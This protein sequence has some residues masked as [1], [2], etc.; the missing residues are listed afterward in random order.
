MLRQLGLSLL[1]ALCTALGQFAFAQ[2]RPMNT[3][4]IQGIMISAE[5]FSRDSE[6]EIVELTGNVQIVYE[7]QH[8]KC[9]HA[10]ISLRAKSVDAQGNVL[11]VTPKA[12]VGGDRIILDYGSDTGVIFK[13]F[14]QSGNV[15]FEGDLIQKTSSDEYLTSGSRYTT[16]TNCPET[17][18]FSGS[19]IRAE[20]G[21]YAYIK[22]SVLRVGD[23]PIFWLPYMLVPLKSD[24][25]TGLLTP[26]YERSE[27]GGLVLSLPFFWVIDR[28]QDATITLKN[29]ELRG[30]KSLMNYRYALTEKSVG[31]LDMGFLT[32]R[33]FRQDPRLQ[34]FLPPSQQG[35]TLD[36][37][38]IKYKHFY[39]MPEGFT[40]RLMVNNASDLQYPKD[41]TEETGNH[42]DS[43]MESR[44]SLTKNT[45]NQH[46]MVD[47]SYYTNLMQSN[48]LANNDFSVHRAPEI[49]FSQ[50]QTKIS[51]SSYL[52]SF[53]LNYVKFARNN[54]SYD[55]LNAA[56]NPAGG[57]A[58]HIRSG[59]PLP[60]CNSPDWEKH[61]ECYEDR[62][63]SFDPNVDLIRT[64]QRL[65]L[66]PA[67][68]RPFQI[69]SFDFLPKLSY[70]ETQYTFEVGKDRSNVRR[71]VRGDISARTTFSG[72]FG[73]L[74][75]VK[76]D[77]IKHEI[78]PE[79]SFTTI[80]WMYHPKHPF[81]G[82]NAED[83]QFSYSDS[84]SDGDLNGPNGLQFDYNDRVYDRKLMTFA[85][86]NRLIEKK[87]RMGIPQYRQFLTWRLA[88]SYD[89]Y[90]A[91]HNPSGEKWSDL[92]SD[93][94][95]YLDNVQIY[96][97]ANY[98]PQ[99]R[100][101]NVSSRVRLLNDLGDYIELGHL[102]S[103]ITTPG[104]TG[105]QDSRTEEIKTTIRKQAK[106][107]NLLG[108]LTYDINPP[109]DRAF[110]KSWG[111]GAQLKMPG[112]CLFVNFIQYQVTGGDR[113]EKIDFVFFWDGN[114]QPTLNDSILQRFEF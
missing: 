99:A 95:L 74:R 27:F 10:T 69:G 72:I 59:G 77:R 101:T 71:Y 97:R 113:T 33:A 12:T 38:F 57:N 18:S 43:A 60:E 102:L 94:R 93:F 37:W 29:Y 16:C 85:L 46:Y 56:Y 41:F 64:G 104:A 26:G 114:E 23:I 9:D 63:G 24:R 17:W 90:Q 20:L 54:F 80:P 13:G 88:Q 110:L 44:M 22:N 100:V 15:L 78:Q 106:W 11:L 52:Y 58:R 42:G 21:G 45:A 7:D 81:F 61:S 73:D 91:E 47:A 75:S 107:V 111:Y 35:K 83:S 48:P 82:S 31:E 53:D 4:R 84:I 1:F 2:A 8:L 98:F 40:H 67:L 32:D 79:I 25:Q 34:A 68:Y 49:A 76:S 112:D 66:Q 89:F 92:V 50:K 109:K 65:D 87:W 103:Y 86:V 96:Q 36:R 28:S 51:D 70:R 39:E 55:D 62:D 19:L 6:K 108:Q 105:L 3:A 5:S 14:V 30:L